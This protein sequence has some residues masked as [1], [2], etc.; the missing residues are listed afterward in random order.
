MIDSP[1][2]ELH[3]QSPARNGAA[4]PA[5]PRVLPDQGDLLPGN[6]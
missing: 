1:N 6:V 2:V 5:I 3:A 4:L